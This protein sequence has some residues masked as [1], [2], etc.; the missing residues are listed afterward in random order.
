MTSSIRNTISPI[1]MTI[2]LSPTDAM[3]F[4]CIFMPIAAIAAV[5]RAQGGVDTTRPC[6]DST[7]GRS[8]VPSAGRYS[9]EH[10]CPP[11][12]AVAAPV[13]HDDA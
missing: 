8:S 7:E 3:S 5:A 13:I 11:S 10:S 2:G 9:D 4:N 6:L 1:I 12:I